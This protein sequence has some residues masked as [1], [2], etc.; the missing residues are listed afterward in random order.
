MHRFHEPVSRPAMLLEGYLT[1]GSVQEVEDMQTIYGPDGRVEPSI[2]IH[3]RSR[4]I[5]TFFSGPSRFSHMLD[6]FLTRNM[7][8]S[9]GG[10]GRFG[11][12]LSSSFA[13]A[14]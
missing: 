9:Y 1:T 4:D 6:I 10:I 8:S 13:E 2:N 3:A 7:D 14:P 5:S 11:A 12:G